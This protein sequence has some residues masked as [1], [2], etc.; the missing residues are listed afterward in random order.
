MLDTPQIAE[1]AVQLAAVI[2]ITIPRAQIRTVMG[3]G[4]R[5]LMAAIAAQGIAPTGPWFAH[6]LK[7]DPD[8]FNFEIGVP[9]A[10]PVAAAGRVKPGQLPATRVARTVYRGAYEGLGAAWGEFH[11]WIADRGHTPGTDLW[12]CF[13][14]G[15]ESSPDPT[16]WRTEL[17]RQLID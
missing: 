13:L 17:N 6:H 15:P 2:P 16:A 10:V 14:K 4:I 1:T 7:M 9:I 3:P 8:T 11:A 5:E 12:E